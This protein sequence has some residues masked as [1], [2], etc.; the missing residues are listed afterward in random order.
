MKDEPDRQVLKLSDAF[1]TEGGC[2]ECEVVMLNINYGRNR[3]LMEKC[4]RL[5]EYSI[6]VA[7]VRKYASNK[8]LT[9]TESISQAI[10]ECIEAG[11]LTDI[12]TEQRAEV[13]MYI[14]ESFDKEI[15]ERDLKAEAEAA[16]LA[17]GMT[18]GAREKVKELVQR[19]LAKGNTVEEIAEWLEEDIDLIR[20]LK[21]EL[22]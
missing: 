12:L 8:N 5:E 10:N 2:I 11:V 21:N 17:E 14:L 16:G 15:Y 20:E 3:E 13:T 22:G 4:R 6:F 7:T 18:K 9:L 19:K 1:Q